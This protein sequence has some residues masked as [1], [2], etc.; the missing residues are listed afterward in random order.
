MIGCDETG[1]DEVGCDM[2]G[3]DETGCDEL[4]ALPDCA[5]YCWPV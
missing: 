1:C 4:E 5:S 3:C 2:T